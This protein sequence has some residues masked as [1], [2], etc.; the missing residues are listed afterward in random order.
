MKKT[1]LRILALAMLLAL[2]VGAL[3][4]LAAAA[5]S[6]IVE[7]LY[8][9]T[10]S[11]RMNIRNWSWT[12]EIVSVKSSN[13]GVLKVTDADSLEATPRKAGKATITVKYKLGGKSYTIKGKY[14]V[15]AYP[16]P[17]KSLTVNGERIKLTE[18]QKLRYNHEAE[19]GKKVSVTI[20]LKPRAGWKITKIKAYTRD[21]WNSKARKTTLKVANNTKFTVPKDKE[22]FITYTLENGKTKFDYIVNVERYGE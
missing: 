3:P 18:R 19:Y 13:P 17:V 5:R 21:T 9:G 10:G 16:K 11:Y 14:T 1:A 22:A 4:A 6:I 15:K 2:T 20:N 12:E 8:A 7:P